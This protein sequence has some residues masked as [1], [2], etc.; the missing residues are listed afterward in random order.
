VIPGPNEEKL[1]IR[2]FVTDVGQEKKKGKPLTVRRTGASSV[3]LQGVSSTQGGGR[4]GKKG[5]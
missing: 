4:L 5:S 3:K 1:T 2:K